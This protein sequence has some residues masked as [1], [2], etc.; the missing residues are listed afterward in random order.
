MVTLSYLM[1]RV[2]SLVTFFLK[3]DSSKAPFMLQVVEGMGTPTLLQARDIFSFHGVTM[4]RLND[5]I[6]AGTKT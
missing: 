6:R 2:P 4:L 1:T 5:V 3:V